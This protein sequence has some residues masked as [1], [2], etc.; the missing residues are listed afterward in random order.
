MA[1]L[2]VSSENQLNMNGSALMT[3]Y[4]DSWDGKKLN[5]S[6]DILGDD[7]KAKEELLN[8]LLIKKNH[9]IRNYEV[10]KSW[11]KTEDWKIIEEPFGEY[12]SHSLKFQIKHLAIDLKD[13][14][15]GL[16]KDLQNF[17]LNT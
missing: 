3:E 10:T 7:D 13:I 11:F 15:S 14:L 1:N 17:L 16:R 5:G 9:V 2:S 8:W 4:L 12:P 6:I